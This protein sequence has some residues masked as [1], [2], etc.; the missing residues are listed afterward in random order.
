MYNIIHAVIESRRYALQDMLTKIDVIWLQGQITEQ[1]RE[2]LIKLAREHAD[3]AMSLDLYKALDALTAR[4]EALEEK[5]EGI[6][7]PYDP[8]KLYHAGDEITFEGGHYICTAPEGMP[9]SWSPADYPAYW[10][11]A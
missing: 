3:P 9:C 1:E 6:Y 7:P 4:V 5:K 10:T 2:A 8:R 11:E